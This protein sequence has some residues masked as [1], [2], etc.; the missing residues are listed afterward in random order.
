MLAQ[1][2]SVGGS[3]PKST[4]LYDGALWIA[5]FPSL[6]DRWSNARVEMATMKFAEECGIDISDLRLLDVGGRDVLLVKSFDR[7]PVSGGFARIAYLSAL[8]LCRMSETAHE[9]FS[10]E[11]VADHDVRWGVSDVSSIFKRIA[12]N[13]LCR[14]TDYHPRNHG[15]LVRGTSIFLAP[16]FDIVSTTSVHGV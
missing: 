7:V 3:R 14:N 8:S 6:H 2:S 1:G 10:Y 13:F 5:K 4:V 11:T 16:A 9:A 12:F 15:F